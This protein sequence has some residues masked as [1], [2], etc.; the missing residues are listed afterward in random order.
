MEERM[1]FLDIPQMDVFT[2]DYSSVFSVIEECGKKGKRTSGA[3]K[4]LGNPVFGL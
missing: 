1:M 4:L 3:A 2:E